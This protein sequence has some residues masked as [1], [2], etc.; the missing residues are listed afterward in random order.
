MED[1]ASLNAEIMIPSLVRDVKRTRTER[2]WT[3]ESQNQSL[4]SLFTKVNFIF[5]WK[6]LR[7]VVHQLLK[8]PLFSNQGNGEKWSPTF[9]VLVVSQPKEEEDSLHTR[10]FSKLRI[11]TLP[12]L[13]L[14]GLHLPFHVSAEFLETGRGASTGLPLRTYSVFPTFETKRFTKRAASRNQR[15]LSSYLSYEHGLCLI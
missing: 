14:T 6:K 11:S 3:D 7:V 5:S 15:P 13:Q 8:G 1:V 4:Y 2:T 9:H 10:F 12:A